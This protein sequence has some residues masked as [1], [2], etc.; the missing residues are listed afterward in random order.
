MEAP[1]GPAILCLLYKVLSSKKIVYIFAKP[2]YM[3][4]DEKYHKTPTTFAFRSTSFLFYGFGS[5]L[6]C[7]EFCIVLFGLD[8]AWFCFVW[9]WLGFIW[10][11]LGLVLFGSAE[12]CI[13]FSVRE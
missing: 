13:L 11:G 2:P 7:M 9:I 6:L 8:L 1:L 4:V 3:L 12:S 5:F 10:F